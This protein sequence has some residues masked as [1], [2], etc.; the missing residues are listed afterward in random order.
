VGE[1]KPT[2]LDSCANIT[3]LLSTLGVQI[4]LSVTIASRDI[5]KRELS[6]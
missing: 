1:T 3:G 5:L 2:M 4:S 6:A